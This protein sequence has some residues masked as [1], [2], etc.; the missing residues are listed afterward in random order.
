MIRPTRKGWV[1]IW[2]DM[3][4]KSVVR[5]HRLGH[6]WRAG[7]GVIGEPSMVL[8]ITFATQRDAEACCSIMRGKIPTPETMT[9]DEFREAF[10]GIGG[11]DMQAAC[12][13]LVALSCCW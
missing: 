3:D 7:F 1:A 5:Q 13:E 9:L 2:S 10:R 8:P 4:A 11:G 6:A 12:D